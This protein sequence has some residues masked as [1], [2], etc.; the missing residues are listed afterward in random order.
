[1]DHDPN[2]LF[3]RIVAG[4]VDATLV[5]EGDD[6]IAFRDVDPRAPTHVLVIPRRHVVSIAHLRPEDARL[7]GRLL[8]VAAELARAE[9]LEGGWR[10][11][12][13]VG[14]DAGQ[15]VPHLHVHLLGGRTLSWP[16]G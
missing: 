2:C 15:S 3:C 4:E 10:V 9:G 11:V 8:L 12:S 13:N 1:M 14:G 6:V 16:P 7:A 5:H